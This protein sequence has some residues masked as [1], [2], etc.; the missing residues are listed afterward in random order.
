MSSPGT[1]PTWPWSLDENELG[2]RDFRSTKFNVYDATLVNADD[3]GVRVAADADVN[4]RACL[5]AD[6]VVFHCLQARQARA[7]SADATLVGH[8]YMS[9][10]P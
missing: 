6:G 7:V 8:V 2:T 5:D 1:P 10:V 9:I 4:V 3:R